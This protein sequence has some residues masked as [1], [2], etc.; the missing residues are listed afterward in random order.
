MDFR[1]GRSS[2]ET[3]ALTRSRRTRD[4]QC[5]EE[6]FLVIENLLNRYQDERVRL[7]ELQSEGED[8]EGDEVATE[9]RAR[10]ELEILTRTQTQFIAP[11]LTTDTPTTQE[12][13]TT[14]IDDLGLGLGA[15][16]PDGGSLLG[17]EIRNPGSATS[18]LTFDEVIRSQGANRPGRSNVLPTP[19]WEVPPTVTEASREPPPPTSEVAAEI[20]VSP[21]RKK[22]PEVSPGTSAPTND[23]VATVTVAVPATVVASL[24]T[25]TATTPS[26]LVYPMSSP[27]ADAVAS[28]SSMGRSERRR[29]TSEG[30]APS[31]PGSSQSESDQ[32][33]QIRQMVATRSR[34]FTQNLDAVLARARSTDDG[35]PR[36]LPE[37]IRCC[38]RELDRLEEIEGPAWSLIGRLEGKTA[39]SRRIEK[40]RDWMTRQTDRIR[41]AKSICWDA[42]QR[43]TTPAPRGRSG[44][45]HRSTGH[46][47]KVKLPTFTGRQEDFS[48][49]RNQF[50]ELCAG[51]RYTPILE[52]A[53][54]KLKLPKEAL[55]AISGLQCPEEAWKRL[56]ELYG[57]RELSILTAIKNLREFRT[58]KTTA[59]EQTIDIAMA[60]QKC[61]TE[62]KNIDA[63][64]DLLGDRESIA[65][66]LMALPQ[67]VRD[68]WYD[69]DVPEETRA[70]GDFLIKW[71]EKQRQNAGPRPTRHHGCQTEN[72]SHTSGETN[73][74]PRRVDRQ[75]FER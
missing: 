25:T 11:F 60:T 17:W 42:T 72:A 27:S 22:L 41:Q 55:S 24:T 33:F 44:S 67:T 69:I 9:E 62:L 66:I 20:G 68:K 4:T 12:V 56:E 39:Q 46:V 18:P 6:Q 5:E 74:G 30:D 21:P 1:P 14:E 37:E 23:K 13:P 73:S 63:V 29:S 71:L 51:E 47:E 53:Q 2:I 43:E 34:T 28:L 58:A 26:P 49:F 75:G 61:L 38:Q 19:Q 35:P 3:T 45:C 52:M 7:H 8:Q 16:S 54:M 50:R 65:C 32:L 64:G 59:H 70:K 57:N 15:R 31:K 36:W 10:S 48:E 40:W